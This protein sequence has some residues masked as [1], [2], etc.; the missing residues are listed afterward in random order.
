VVGPRGIGWARMSRGYADL[1]GIAD[2]SA[3]SFAL[4]SDALECGFTRARRKE[5]ERRWQ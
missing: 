5:F 1:I 3:L 2:A 4:T